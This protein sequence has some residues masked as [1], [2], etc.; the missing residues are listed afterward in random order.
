MIHALGYLALGRAWKIII[1]AFTAVLIGT[2]S[3]LLDSLGG[4]FMAHG[5]P[6]Y[7]QASSTQIVSGVSDLGELAARL[8]SADTFDRRGNVIFMDGFEH[9]LVPYALNTYNTTAYFEINQRAVYSGAWAAHLNTGTDAT[10]RVNILKGLGVA[11]TTRQ[12][13]EVSFYV[14]GG[15][16]DL[17]FTI[18]FWDGTNSNSWFI[19]YHY[20]T[21]QLQYRGSDGLDH[22]FGAPV[23]LVGQDLAFHTAKL[24]VDLQTKKYVRFIIDQTTF[25][26]S[27]NLGFSA[28]NPQASEV[29]TA[30]DI[31]S[32]GG[33]ISEAWLDNWII[34]I[35]EP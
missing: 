33:V 24:V 31:I 2:V 7:L 21:G 35:N 5:Q 9:G 26:L 8:G 22:N 18:N 13:F 14:L 12:G 29:T 11:R 4:D 17:R 1:T 25:D 32:S 23:P 6:D 10:Q 34:T 27:A 3:I 15:T 20:T 19:T 30:F 16:P 28:A